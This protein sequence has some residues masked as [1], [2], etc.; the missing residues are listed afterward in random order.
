VPQRAFHPGVQAE[1]P[2]VHTW[3]WVFSGIAVVVLGWSSAATGAQVPLLGGVDF[4]IHEFGHLVTAW[5]PWLVNAFAGSFLQVA[6]PLGLA[7]Y[8]GLV[9]HEIWAAAPLIAWAGTSTRNVAVYIADAPYQRLELW[10]GDGV[11][12]DW[13]QILAGTPMQHAEQIAWWTNV[14]GWALIAGGLVL[15]VWAAFSERRA[16]SAFAAKRTA[17]EARHATLPVREPRGPIG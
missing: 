12:H 15:V 3:R 14:A 10:G 11:L 1:A 8:F 9:R 13:A 17:D 5:A 2:L 6:A 7:A 16:A 4:G